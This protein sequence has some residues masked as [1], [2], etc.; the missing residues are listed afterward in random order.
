MNPTI[1]I[2]ARLPTVDDRNASGD[3]RGPPS[4]SERLGALFDQ[5]LSAQGDASTS[6]KTQSVKSDGKDAAADATPRSLVQNF[7]LQFPPQLAAAM[8]PAPLAMSIAPAQAAQQ[9]L[10]QSPQSG[11][12]VSGAALPD[13]AGQL[14]AGDAVS[15]PDLR[16][17]AFDV[18][19]LAKA[20]AAVPPT[21]GGASVDAPKFTVTSLVAHLPGA[22]ARAVATPQTAPETAPQAAGDAANPAIAAVAADEARASTRTPVADKGAG[23]TTFAD[24]ALAPGTALANAA[25]SEKVAPAAGPAEA[26][27]QDPR[28][29][30]TS[31]K[32]LTFQLTPDSLGPVTVR[33]Q[34]T[35]G[36]VAVKIDVT[37]TASHDALDRSRE[38]IAQALGSAGQ[39]LDDIS[40]RVSSAPGTSAT[41][42]D[43][44]QS[45][46]LA[47]QEPR[48]D[49]G[50]LGA[51]DGSTDGRDKGS[52]RPGKRA[53]RPMEPAP[54]R[55]A[56]SSDPVGLYL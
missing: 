18:T 27:I 36:R 39:S 3:R 50:S 29:Q 37:S 31:T 30:T 25:A 33:M 54:A 44:R 7:V 12:G 48:G 11:Q 21:N 35:G 22:I 20:S 23:E 49:G 10:A 19:S 45:D 9:M 17:P 52:S 56:R 46:S 28:A 42:D 47:Q 6:D 43:T 26:L 13:L 2:T 32:I 40:I 55:G 16:G 15:R 53:A 34:L 14:G 24:F 8:A 51:N 5:A 41:T 1:V 38:A 4:D